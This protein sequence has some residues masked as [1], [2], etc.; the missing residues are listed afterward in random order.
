[1]TKGI[2]YP[3]TWPKNKKPNRSLDNLRKA[4]KKIGGWQALADWAE[5]NKT[6]F[7]R[8]WSKTLP[9]EVY[10][11]ADMAVEQTS[12]IIIE[13]VESNPERDLYLQFVGDD[14]G[15]RAEENDEA[16]GDE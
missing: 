3:Q 1:M 2:Q 10:I 9:R 11:D 12:T 13:G 6:E 4:F 15:D 7:Y 5:D 16:E 14:Y 8:I